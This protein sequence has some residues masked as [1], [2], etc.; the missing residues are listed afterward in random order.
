MTAKLDFGP[1]T[2]YSY[3]LARAF[4]MQTP[5]EVFTLRVLAWSLP[6][7]PVIVNIGAG[8]GTSSLSFAESRK[9]ARIYTVDISEGGPLG[10]M[11]NER[12]AFNDTKDDS[13]LFPI[14]VIGDSKI[15]GKKWKSGPAD[16][17]LI[18]GDHSYAGCLGDI[19]AWRDHVKPGGLLALHDYDRD[20]WPDV[21]RAVDGGS[22]EGFDQILLV[23]TLIV[24]RKRSK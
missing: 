8:T 23:D 2:N 10:G 15:I 3:D 18:D 20:V 19:E 14:Q 12:N 6:E 22:L 1:I 11:E 24:F 5:K 9:D 21:A 16:L 7:N 4:G 17:I 13:L